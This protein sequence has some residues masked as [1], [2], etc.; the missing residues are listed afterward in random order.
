MTKLTA[1]TAYFIKLGP[2]G[3]W[4]DKSLRDGIIRFG[5]GETPHDLCMLGDWTAVQDKWTTLRNGDRGTA[6][7]D[8]NQI[9]IFYEADEEAIFITFSGGLMYWCRPS[10][11]VQLL[12]DGNRWRST[13]DGWHSTSL[14]G[15]PLTRD[16]ISG[17]LQKVEMFRGTICKVKLLDYL[18]RK[19]GDELSPELAQADAAEHSMVCAIKNLMSLLTWQDFE[20]LVD[21]VFSSSGWRRI[22]VVGRTQKT[23]DLELI[24]PTTEER[25]FVQVKSE[26]T[27]NSLQEYVRELG[28]SGAYTRMFFVWHSG[29]FPSSTE[30]RVTLLGP[31]RLAKM[32]LDTGLW[33]WLRNKVS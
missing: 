9:R 19:I 23:V 33:S 7:R 28:R 17:G 24:L 10:G 3:T 12:K 21:L 1:K 8:A 30:D 11:E 20:L 14:N 27:A 29:D 25:A 5:Y 13:V 16:R 26:A 18:L 15:L 6:A 22:N 4:E 2:G 31:D 32:V